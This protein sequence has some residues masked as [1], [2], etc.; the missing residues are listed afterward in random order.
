MRYLYLILICFLLASCQKEKTY[1]SKE[2]TA[3]GPEKT[4]TLKINDSLSYTIKY[5]RNK[6]DHRYG[7]YSTGIVQLKQN[8]F[9][10]AAGFL[11]DY[12]LSK[13][14]QVI[15]FFE[16]DLYQKEIPVIA[17]AKAYLIYYADKENYLTADYIN[18]SANSK[19][20]YRV[21]EAWCDV[22]SHYLFNSGIKNKHVGI[23]ITNETFD[24]SKTKTINK[25]EDETYK[26]Y[27]NHNNSSL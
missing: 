3:G 9:N 15:L 16:T 7:S 26:R 17:E 18:P 14:Y 5:I 12:D 4:S 6:E 19:E 20:S 21:R 1:T 23:G 10:K 25:N 13:I 11:K 27:V 24:T 2:T 22:V 8:E